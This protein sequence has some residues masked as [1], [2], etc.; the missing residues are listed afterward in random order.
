[1]KMGRETTRTKALEEV[2]KYSIPK[3]APRLPRGTLHLAGMGFS[4]HVTEECM[5]KAREAYRKQL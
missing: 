3:Q 2:R 5:I 4:S 1:M